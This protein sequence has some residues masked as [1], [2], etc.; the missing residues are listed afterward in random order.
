M[1]TKGARKTNK[2]FYL[3]AA[4]SSLS[5]VPDAA[6]GCRSVPSLSRA[7]VLQAR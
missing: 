7:N 4:S 5:D 6:E 1:E 3:T 2:F